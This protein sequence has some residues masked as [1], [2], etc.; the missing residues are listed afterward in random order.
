M[1]FYTALETVQICFPND[2]GVL[3]GGMEHVRRLAPVIPGVGN[4]L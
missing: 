2:L 1:A 4:R 3:Q